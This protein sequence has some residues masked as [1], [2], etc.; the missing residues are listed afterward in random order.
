MN[1]FRCSNIR[2]VTDAREPSSRVLDYQEEATG[3]DP[4]VLPFRA[5][6]S[7][8]VGLDQGR[9]RQLPVHSHLGGKDQRRDPS[10]VG[11]AQ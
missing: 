8:I 9:R 10:F 3:P 4:T 1:F 11:G 7:P 2:K 5:V 6:S